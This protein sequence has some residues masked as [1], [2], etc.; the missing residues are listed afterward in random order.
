MR[1]LIA[2]DE[3]DISY[4]YRVALEERSHEVVI[5]NNGIDCLKTYHEEWLKTK[6]R[7]LSKEENH[8]FFTQKNKNDDNDDDD[9]DDSSNNSAWLNSNNNNT[10]PSPFDVVILDYKIPGK[11]GMEVAKEILEVNLNQRIIFA[12]AYVKDTL[13]ESVKKL[14]R[15][16]ELLQKPF[17]MEAFVDA[18][19]DREAYEG[20]KTL[21]VNIR[22]IEDLQQR[23]KEKYNEQQEGEEA[24]SPSQEQIRALFE[25]LR[26]IQKYRTF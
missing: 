12:S 10:S 7:L 25:G 22:G 1:V 9:D 18:I 20:L 16:V 8:I 17:S 23:Q 26:K 5:V 6:Q 3:P 11:D 15:V 13:Q 21:M 19:E 24:Y 14:K 4:A 2:E